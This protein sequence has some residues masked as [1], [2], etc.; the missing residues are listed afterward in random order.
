MRHNLYV[1]V[2][3]IHIYRQLGRGKREYDIHETG[4]RQAEAERVLQALL[5]IRKPS[6]SLLG[7]HTTAS[8]CSC[9]SSKRVT[10]TMPSATNSSAALRALAQSVN[11]TGLVGRY[12]E[13]AP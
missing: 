2:I 8:S 6:L 3:I 13:T 9:H 5:R 1:C 10:V 11:S 4:V 7:F 12:A